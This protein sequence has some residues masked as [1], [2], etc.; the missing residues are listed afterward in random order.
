VS[1][2]GALDEDPL[3]RKGVQGAL[4]VL[5][6]LDGTLLSTTYLNANAT[7]PAADMFST[8]PLVLSSADGTSVLL[9]TTGGALMSFAADGTGPTWVANELPAIPAEDFPASTYSFLSVTSAGAVLLTTTAGGADWQTEKSFVAVANGAF[10]PAGG[11]SQTATGTSSASA[12]ASATASA[13]ATATA[14]FSAGASDSN[15]P[16]R[17]PSRTPSRTAARTPSQ[18]AA[19]PAAAPS[20]GAA[21]LSPG[22]AAGVAFIVIAAVAAGGIWAFATFFGGGPVVAGAFAALKGY[23]GVAG[24]GGGGGGEGGGAKS[25]TLRATGERVKLL[26]PQQAAGRLSTFSA[27]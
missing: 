7:D 27:P 4:A 25:P 8:A 24:G 22:A 18:S 15:T 9:A 26:S 20:G 11:A 6:T 19:A 3:N 2:S 12:T 23:A 13:S 5:D 14:T 17:T 16:T 10:A 1:M 21:A